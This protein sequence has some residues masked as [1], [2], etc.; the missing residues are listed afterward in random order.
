M[1]A[2]PRKR[3]GEGGAAPE[4]RRC[5]W[6]DGWRPR[7]DDRARRRR[8]AVWRGG[9]FR[10][11]IQWLDGLGWHVLPGEQGQ[12]QLGSGLRDAA[13][14]A[15][16]VKPLPPVA[17]PGAP[18]DPAEAAGLFVDGVSERRLVA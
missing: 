17:A 16:A 2:H 9:W 3:G 18:G 12:R 1:G 8:V 10:E 7:S 15:I 4:R 11:H 13:L 6:R 5:G 14:G